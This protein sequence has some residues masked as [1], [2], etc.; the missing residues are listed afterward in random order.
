M[1]Y[2]LICFGIRYHLL[3]NLPGTAALCLVIVVEIV[4][5]LTAGTLAVKPF[6]QYSDLAP[7]VPSS[8]HKYSISFYYHGPT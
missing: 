2:L 8:W 4:I 3:I 6:T 7:R 5:P 1:L